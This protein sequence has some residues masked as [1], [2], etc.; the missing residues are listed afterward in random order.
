MVIFD[1]DPSL[2]SLKEKWSCDNLGETKFRNL[3]SFPEARLKM[4]RFG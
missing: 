1:L 4:L 3:N 2:V